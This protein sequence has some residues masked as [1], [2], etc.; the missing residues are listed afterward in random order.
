MVRIGSGS[1]F[2][3]ATGVPTTGHGNINQSGG[4]AHIEGELRIGSGSLGGTSTLGGVYVHRGGEMRVSNSSGT[5][6]LR[7]ALA[8]QLVISGGTVTADRIQIDA[9]QL[10]GPGNPARDPGSLSGG[11]GTIIG[12]VDIAGILSPGFQASFPQNTTIGTL[13]I[14]GDLTLATTA[15]TFFDFKDPLLTAG[16]YDSIFNHG[17]STVSFD[18]DL[19]LRF[20]GGEYQPGTVDLFAN[21]ANYSGDFDSLTI[22]G[23]THGELATFNPG[24]GKLTISAVPEPSGLLLLSLGLGMLFLTRRQ[25]R[26]GHH[27]C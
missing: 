18:G 1:P 13:N 4:T 26:G 14:F 10:A 24:N 3:T 19:T 2:G 23:L 20:F 12:T 8:S 9:G 25:S 27:K 11:V 6:L 16:T 17:T 5:G 21:F 15:E 22:T 7:I